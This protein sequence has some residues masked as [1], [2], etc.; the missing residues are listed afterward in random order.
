M[1]EESQIENSMKTMNHYIAMKKHNCTSMRVRRR[2]SWL[3]AVAALGLASRNH[4]GFQDSPPIATGGVLHAP[5]SNSVASGSALLPIAAM[6]DFTVEGWMFIPKRSAYTGFPGF[7]FF[8]EGLAVIQVQ[9]SVMGSQIEIF[10]GTATGEPKQFK[11]PNF[12]RSWSEYEDSWHH[13]ACVHDR[14]TQEKR[15]YFDGT[16]TVPR[17]L[18]TTTYG[19]FPRDL[20]SIHIG[21]EVEDRDFAWGFCYDEIRVSK[22]V[23][24]ATN[25]APPRA[26]LPTDA[27]TVALWH[28]DEIEGA[29]AFSDASGLGHSLEGQNGAQG[30]RINNAVGPELSIHRLPDGDIEVALKGKPGRTYFIESSGDLEAWESMSSF[31]LEQT[32]HALIVP[33]SSR[34]LMFFRGQE[35]TAR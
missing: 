3:F 20:G 22:A 5:K 25:F 28:F 17:I 32:T 1:F 2:W 23:R 4:A 11:G 21:G 13:I 34:K 30:T 35:A 9:E 31:Q 33:S 6:E 24:Y 16:I 26:L 7:L 29:T 27:D 15:I 8:Q 10:F 18:Q 12:I 19:I 14:Q